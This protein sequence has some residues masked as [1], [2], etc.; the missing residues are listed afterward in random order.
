MSISPR[1]SV[2]I[3]AYNAGKYLVRSIQSALDQTYSEPYEVI[4]VNDGS[5]DRTETICAEYANRFEKVSYFTIAN[6][7]PLLARRFGVTKSSGEYLIF[8]DSDDCLHEKALDSFNTAINETDADI[9]CCDFSTNPDYVRKGDVG[10]F[11]AD[12]YS[13]LNYVLIKESACRCSFNAIW[14]RAVRRNCFDIDKDYTPYVGLSYAEDLFQLIPIVDK[15]KTY[16]KLNTSLYYYRDNG[17]SG[18]S[19]FKPSQLKDVETVAVRLLDY[20]SRWE[21]PCKEAAL[22]GCATLYINL[23]KVSE[24]SAASQSEKRSSFDLISNSVVS[25]H[26]LDGFSGKG[27]RVDNRFLFSCLMGGYYLPAHLVFQI[28]KHIKSFTHLSDK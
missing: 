24:L 15:A 16:V 2:I 4:I 13:G 7:G 9:A 10:E 3:P 19:R 17:E 21:E 6:S 25:R 1:F 18:T 28:V 14:G 8:L 26:L 12:F 22:V 20:G 5:S 23:F 11:K 27:L